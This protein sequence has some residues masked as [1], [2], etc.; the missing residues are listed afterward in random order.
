MTLALQ[1]CSKPISM[2]CLKTREVWEES[3]SVPGGAQGA[4]G[5]RDAIGSVGIAL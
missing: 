3:L 4:R 1:G 2:R 5:E